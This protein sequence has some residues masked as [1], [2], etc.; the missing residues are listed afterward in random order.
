[1]VSRNGEA[2]AN[3]SPE[4]CPAI[5]KCRAPPTSNSA[6]SINLRATGGNPSRPS[7]PMPT[8]D[9]QR[10]RVPQLAVMPSIVL[11]SAKCRMRVLILGGSSEASALAGLLAS[12]PAFEITLSLAGRTANPRP[13][14]VPTRS[15]GFGGSAGLARFLEENGIDAILDATHPFASQMSRNAIEAAEATGTPLLAVE[16]PTWRPTSQDNWTEVTDTAAAVAALGDASRTVFCGIGRLALGE[17]AKAPQHRYV[18]RLIDAPE[19][20]LGL[21]RVTVIQATGPF[22]SEGDMALFRDHGV[23][24]ILAKNS[25]GSAT[26]SKIEAA[27]TLGLPVIMVSRPFIPPR[28]TVET[29]ALA[30]DW[31]NR[32]QTGAIER[33]V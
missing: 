32:L 11:S 1:M 28:P 31:L 14:P 3:F 20:P 33:G 18:I 6:L 9:N 2:Q 22:T 30:I 19:Q 23:E 7:S 15:G 5:A 8:I 21:P 17:L 26:I 13:Q 12:N 27:R 10:G 29:P 25:G 4:T 24:V 16:R